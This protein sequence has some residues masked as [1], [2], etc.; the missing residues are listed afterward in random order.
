MSYLTIDNF[1]SLSAEDI[2]RTSVNHVLKNGAKSVT[3]DLC[4]YSGI[5]CA[6]AP[7]IK[8]E[9]HATADN[10]PG[11][12]EWGSLVEIALVSDLHATLIGKL[13][14]AHDSAPDEGNFIEHYKLRLQHIFAGSAYYPLIQELTS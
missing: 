14:A 12:S 1:E 6:A 13:Q 11:G 2:I 10:A 5:G 7:F 4:C 9:H 8:P 3:D